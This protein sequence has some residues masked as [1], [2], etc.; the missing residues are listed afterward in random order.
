MKEGGEK[1]C[2]CVLCEKK[3]KGRRARTDE[4]LDP[5]Q[6]SWLRQA[7]QGET[8][9]RCGTQAG[10]ERNASG[11]FESGPKTQA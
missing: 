1:V 4:L 8:G 9:N 7:S 10:N 5:R 6:F 3:V 11:F 2:E